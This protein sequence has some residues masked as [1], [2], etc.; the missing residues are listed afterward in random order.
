MILKTYSE[1]SKLKTFE[2][3]FQYLR[4][5]GI[6]G[7]ETFG[8]DRYLNQILYQSKEWKRCRRDIII[9]DE[10]CDLGC[11]GFEIHGRILIHHINPITVDDI[12]N[13]NPK[14]FDPENLILTS[15]N[16]HQAIHYGNEDLLI[17]AP[18]ERSKYD[19]CP[20]RRK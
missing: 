17:R 15:H 6:V 8:F 1:L 9:R 16:T 20:W 3:R 4:L 18:I 10:G 19:T 12:V 5:D 2:D 11:E 14:V 13:R 7:E